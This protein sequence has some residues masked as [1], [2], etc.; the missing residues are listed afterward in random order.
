VIRLS[1]FADEI[2]PNPHEQIAVLRAE[3]IRYVE[4]RSVWHT[5]VLDFTDDEVRTIRRIFDRGGIN[6]AS[7]ASPIG[8]T[9]IDAPADEHVRRFERAL[10]IAHA[11]DTPFIRLFSFYP[12]TGAAETDPEEYRAE[13]LARCDDMVQRATEAPEREQEMILL[14]ENEK[15]IYGDTIA[16]CVDLLEHVR[17]GR[18][19]AAFDPA[20]FIQCGQIPY[21]DAYD[22]LR[23]WI[24][25]VHVKDA[26]LDGT[27]TPAGEGA[28]RWPELLERLRADT[29][30]GFFALEP[31]LAA[32]GTY[33]GYSG[34]ELFRAASQAFQSLL[35]S[36]SWEYS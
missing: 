17:D 10:T 33:G 35:R 29:Y 2:S 22:A 6:V 9:P 18:F 7:I 24:R 5:N 14:H 31:H 1:A 36:M 16:R 12:P 30:D 21:P 15:N 11:F 25:Y 13:V 20:N 27:V 19:Y 34:P 8:K 32:A 4:L 26:R 3:G 23:P 28:A